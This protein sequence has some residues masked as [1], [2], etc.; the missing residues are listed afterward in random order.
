[1]DEGD[2]RRLW[3]KGNTDGRSGEVRARSARGTDIWALLPHRLGSRRP[4]SNPNGLRRPFLK[5]LVHVAR[6]YLHA[7][8]WTTNQPGMRL[9][10]RLEHQ[11]HV[12]S[13]SR[14]ITISPATNRP[15]YVECLTT[16]SKSRA[17]RAEALIPRE[18]INI[19]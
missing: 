3:R 10:I 19:G 9:P 15:A 5:K 12:T 1:M 2:G 16:P 17:V 18:R 6:E 11:R 7:S 14:H 4:S 13:L 8:Q